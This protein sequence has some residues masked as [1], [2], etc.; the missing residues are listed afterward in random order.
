[1]SKALDFSVS[2]LSIHDGETL[3]QVCVEPRLLPLVPEIQLYLLPDAYPSESVSAQ[4]YFDLMAQPPYWAFCWGG[5][6]A[7]AR[8]LLDNPVITN[9]LTVVDLGAGSGV[10]G[11]AAG[12]AGSKRIVAVDIDPKALRACI[13]NSRLNNVILDAVTTIPKTYDLLLAADICYEEAGFDLIRE[14]LAAGKKV[15]VAES[16]IPNLESQIPEL[17][18]VASYKI[19]T[20]PD[21]DESSCFE[22]VNVYLS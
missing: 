16:R 8:Y 3:G 17:A 13:H 15:L 6:Q 11:I 9:G 19:K 21:L 5:G 1:M 2:D 18:H 20:F 12:L 14:T 10:A 4:E 22:S 7:L